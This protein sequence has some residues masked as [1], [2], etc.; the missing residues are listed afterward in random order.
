VR[1]E[2]FEDGATRVMNPV[3]GALRVAA[4]A[5]SGLPDGRFY[6]WR[7][8]V[9]RSDAVRSFRLTIEEAHTISR[10]DAA[11]SLSRKP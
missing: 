7:F 5:A 3:T 11:A 6:A 8:A 9:K 2:A 4:M 1:E 10:A